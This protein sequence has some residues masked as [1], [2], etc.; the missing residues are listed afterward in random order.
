MG[1]KDMKTWIVTSLRDPDW[2]REWNEQ[3]MKEA[4][5][6]EMNS[7]VHSDGDTKRHQLEKVVSNTAFMK[8][9]KEEPSSR[10][11]KGTA[12]ERTGHISLSL[13][14]PDFR[15]EEKRPE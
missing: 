10:T 4:C 7:L 13:L 12:V 8:C 15:I 2:V 5:E 11:S 9:L 1:N 14:F 6:Y 3:Q